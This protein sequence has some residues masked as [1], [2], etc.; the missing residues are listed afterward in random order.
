MWNAPLY[1]KFGTERIQ[2]SVDLV[3]RLS[4]YDFKKILDVGCG[5]GMS[6][7]T[8]ANAWNAAAISGADLSAE[9]LELASASLPDIRFIQR[10]CSK[11]LDDLGKFDLIFSNAFMQWIPDH[12]KFIANCC[13]MLDECG[14]FAA[15]IPLFDSMPASKCI[16]DAAADLPNEYLKDFKERF[17]IHSPEE[18]YL[19]LKKYFGDVQMWTT[20]YYHE[21][22]G[23]E[24]VLEF[25]KGT[26]LRPYFE[27]LDRETMD[28]FLSKALKNLRAAYPSAA[29]GKTLFPFKRLFLIAKKQ[30]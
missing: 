8:L 22:D 17:T 16:K 29:N 9:M 3:N 26:A 12:D 19:I 4:G 14:V 7:V 5:T 10:D 30:T 13:G 18:Y 2:P 6:T 24:S 11:P 20:D 25:L 1:N 23:C 21:M 27:A 15:Q 28:A